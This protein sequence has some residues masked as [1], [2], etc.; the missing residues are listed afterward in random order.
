MAGYDLEID[1][2]RFVSLEVEL[3]V[4]AS[5]DHFRAD[6]QAAVLQALGS[7]TL[8]DGRRGLFHPDNLTFGQSVY[9]SAIYAAAQA[10]QGVESV[11]VTKFERQGQ[12]DPLLLDSGVIELGRLEIARLDNDPDFPEHGVLRVGMGGGK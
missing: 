4:C 12:P 7:R 10:V 6:V 5:P 1:A 9:L 8:P 11:T 3:F 2:P